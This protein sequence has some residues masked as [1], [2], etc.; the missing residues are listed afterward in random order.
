MGDDGENTREQVSIKGV[1]N[2]K[3][4][5]PL[6]KKKKVVAVTPPPFV[7]PSLATHLSSPAAAVPAAVHVPA[8]T[9]MSPSAVQPKKRMRTH[10]QEKTRTV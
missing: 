5:L 9:K 8:T 3:E 4:K 6:K 7:N 1:A 10:T 2:S